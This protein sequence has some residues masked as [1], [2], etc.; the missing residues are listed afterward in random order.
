MSTLQPLG[1]DIGWDLARCTFLTF[2]LFPASGFVV[3]MG[4]LRRMFRWAELPERTD[5]YTWKGTTKWGNH[6]LY[7][8]D[9]KE[10]TFTWVSYVA[11]FFTNGINIS[12]ITLGS[13]FIAY[14]LT[15]GQT[16]GGV[17]AGTCISAIVSLLSSQ[18]GI[19]YH[20]GYVR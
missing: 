4:R 20:M 9:P 5:I 7:P 8:I 11:I 12:T 19:D 17:F 15:A 10:R 2:A 18:P 14:G 6:D 3:I 13:A 16:I 1:S